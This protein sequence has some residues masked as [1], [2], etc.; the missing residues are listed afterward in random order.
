MDF[1]GAEPIGR[2]H[3]TGVAGAVQPCD[4]VFV[5][6]LEIGDYVSVDANADGAFEA[7]VEGFAGTHIL[8][9][10]HPGWGSPAGVGSPDG[11]ATVLLR[12]P[13]QEAQDGVAFSSAMRIGETFD[14]EGWVI[15]GTLGSNALTPGRPVPISGRVLLTVTPEGE[16]PWAEL[17]FGVFLIGDGDGRQVGRGEDFA[18]TFLTPTAS[19]SRWGTGT[20][21]STL[22]LAACP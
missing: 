22:S 18:T 16:P 9:A 5:G 12:L 2:A 6:N 20:S 10:R 4:V 21:A 7:E 1:D 15:N 11:P 8:I 13:V 19:P 3:V 17:D 14:K